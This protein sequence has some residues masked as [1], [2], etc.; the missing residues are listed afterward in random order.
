MMKSV[1]PLEV[2]VESFEQMPT[3]IL[4]R[5]SMANIAPSQS[6]TTSLLSETKQGARDIVERRVLA[7]ED[8]THQVIK[9]VVGHVDGLRHCLIDARNVLYG[10]DEC[11]Q[12][13]KTE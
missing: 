11:P 3:W 5:F 12:E 8:L 6:T 13:T 1:N 9:G 4:Q 10:A 2:A 7:G